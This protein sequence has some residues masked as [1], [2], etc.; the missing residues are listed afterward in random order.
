MYRRF[1]KR[2]LD[3]TLAVAALMLL[4]P[5]MLLVALL[6]RLALGP[7]VLFRQMRPGLHGRREHRVLQQSCRLP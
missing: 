6:V 4:S 2:F 3:L 1:G 7:G 5:L